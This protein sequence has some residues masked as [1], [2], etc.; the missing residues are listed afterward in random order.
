M[1][2]LLCLP[3]ELLLRVI[4]E[5]DVQAIEPFSMCCKLIKLLAA[6]RLQKHLDNKSEFSTVRIA[7]PAEQNMSPVYLLKKVLLHDDI[8][9]YPDTMYIGS[10][11]R[12]SKGL[13]VSD[14]FKDLKDQVVAK[15]SHIHQALRPLESHSITPFW[16]D[17]IARG[18]VD[19]IVAL[20]PTLLPNLKSLWMSDQDIIYRGGY[21]LK[22]VLERLA[23]NNH[24]QALKV[25]PQVSEFHLQGPRADFIG[26]FM[27]L[28]SMRVIIGHRIKWAHYAWPNEVSDLNVGEI[29]FDCS[30]VAIG[31]LQD[32]L[33]RI[34]CL[35]KFTYDYAYISGHRI[36]WVPGRVVQ[37]LQ[38]HARTSLVHLELTCKPEIED[39]APF[40]GTLRSFEV[41]QNIRLMATML[42][43]AVDERGNSLNPADQEMVRPDSP[44]VP[45]RLVDVLPAS[46]TKFHLVGGLSK[47]EV[48][49][50]FEDLPQLKCKRLPNLC[51]I[52]L[53]DN[54]PLE[55]ETKD[56]CKEAGIRLKSLKKVVHGYRRIYTITKPALRVDDLDNH[57]TTI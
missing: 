15:V 28:P 23:T 21:L 18:D 8:A 30:E 43:K 20:L 13:V 32:C 46:A 31:C 12:S 37:A 36:T 16:I 10:T 35:K 17:S 1:A 52:M 2:T 45:Q 25:L 49:D 38:R 33:R 22:H 9:L 48:Q 27:I 54:D 19:A 3:N 44:V 14:T 24:Q 29:A 42:F 41:L 51:E 26:P 50:F 53:E 11:A 55:Q 39:G 7:W 6:D 34:K 47:D 4:N 56:L 57:S 5:L 40:I